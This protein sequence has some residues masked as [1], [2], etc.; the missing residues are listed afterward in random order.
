MTERPSTDN[1]AICYI[2]IGMPKTG[3]TTIQGALAKARQFSEFRYLELDHANHSQGMVAIFSKTPESSPFF[4]HSG[5][6]TEEFRRYA[7]EMRACLEKELSANCRQKFIISGES[8]IG[9]MEDELKDLY[10]LVSRHFTRIHI[11]AYLRP[12][13]SY[14]QSIFQQELKGGSYPTKFQDRYPFY[15]KKIQKFD[16]VFG[17]ENVMLRKYEPAAFPK[18]DVVLD[19]CQLL[20]IN[21]PDYQ[22]IKANESLSL[23]AT[24]LL[25][26]YWEFGGEKIES[27]E[28]AV[29][30]KQKFVSALRKIA[31]RKL[32]FSGEIFSATI[33]ENRQDIEWIEHRAGFSLDSVPATDSSD[34]VSSKDDLMSHSMEGARKLID[35]MGKRF[36]PSIRTP[37][38]PQEAARVLQD[39]VDSIDT[40]RMRRPSI[41]RR[42]RN[43]F[44][45][46][47]P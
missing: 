3:T 4:R 43:R 25:L 37:Q 15:S 1:N 2:H 16:D 8:I 41:F 11:V 39:F 28:N 32:I 33:A 22:S 21:L 27:G 29:L 26:A 34:S 18:Q 36:T 10:Q 46:S 45:K 24:A 30:K 31:G 12:P 14:M 20:G 17:R 23:E 38:T 40:H 6:S 42:L 35:V 7:A 9:L 5:G 19:F 47:K 13:I 44:G